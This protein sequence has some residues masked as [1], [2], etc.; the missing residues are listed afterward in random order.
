MDCPQEQW[1]TN[2][3][4][5]ADFRRR[6]YENRIP[7]SGGINL[8]NRCN[9]RCVHCYIRDYKCGAGNCPELS[10]NRIL[11]IIDEASAAGCLFFLIT[12]GE[13][14][15]HKDFLRIY[16]YARERGMLV[17][18]FTNGTLL[19]DAHV[20]LF[21]ELPPQFIEVTLYGATE[22][23]FDKVAGK[24]G[25]YEACHK[26]INM[27]KE[28]KVPFRLKTM[29]LTLNQHELVQMQEFA[30]ELGVPF[31]FDPMIVPGLDGDRAP[32]K[33]RVDPKD[34][35]VADKFIIIIFLFNFLQLILHN[36]F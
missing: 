9:L 32:L 7:I 10:T 26:G 4:F 19:D 11:S 13:P 27:L 8:T 20:E 23:T 18:V 33:Y 15:L 34:A 6:T 28:G 21:R 24:E 2:T 31:R 36:I 25:A 22:E 16:R 35:A 3:V 14:L 17:S 12:G 30:A 1:L 5:L 29:L